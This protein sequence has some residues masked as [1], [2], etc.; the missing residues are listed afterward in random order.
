MKVFFNKLKR[1]PIVMKIFYFIAMIGYW[2]TY[3]F[4]TKSL[5]SL[6]GI[7]TFIR[8]LLIVLFAIFGIIYTIVALVKMF[9]NKKVAFIILTFFTLVFA[10]IFGF[11]SYYID[12]LY[13]KLENFTTSNTS[14]YT[15]VLLAMDGTEYSN[16]LVI[17][18]ITDEEDRT[19]YILPLEYMSQ[20][21]MENTIEYYSNYTEL[22]QAL[23]SHEVDA[24][25]IMVEKKPIKI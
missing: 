18:M 5:L 9:Q 15:T 20:E 14:V 16:D 7:E 2:V 12:K 21:N 4:F 13:G 6:A 11:G 3:G 23:Y 17:G 24:I 10:V 1:V 19:G 8:I 22:L 25:F